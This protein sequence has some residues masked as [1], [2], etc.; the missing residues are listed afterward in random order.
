MDFPLKELPLKH[1]DILV[2]FHLMA[3]Y[4]P[5]TLPPYFREFSVKS[6]LQLAPITPHCLPACLLSHTLFSLQPMWIPNS[7]NLFVCLGKQTL[8]LSIK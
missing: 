1:S 4:Q 7:F 6:T 3:Q 2:I 8:S 5:Y